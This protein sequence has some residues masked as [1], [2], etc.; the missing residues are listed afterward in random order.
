MLT[1]TGSQNYPWKQ[2]PTCYGFNYAFAYQINKGTRGKL[3][4][5]HLSCQLD[6][7]WNYLEDMHLCIPAGKLPV[8]LTEIGR[9]AWMWAAVSY[10]QD[11]EVV[12]QKKEISNRMSAFISLFFL[13]V[14]ISIFIFSKKG[15]T[16]SPPWWAVSPPWWTVFPLWWTVIP[17]MMGCILTMTVFPPWWTISPPSWA[18]SSSHELYP[19]HHGLNPRKPES[20]ISPSLTLLIVGYLV[21]N[22]ERSN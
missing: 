10:G 12:K 16:L 6:W 7:I 1:S 18:L 20:K 2:K 11:A 5:V 13:T 14:G 22:N 4:I 21:Y 17:T 19:H 8:R 3:T 15:W 9:T